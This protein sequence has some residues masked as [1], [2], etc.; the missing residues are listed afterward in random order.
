MSEWQ[1]GLAK[2]I[3]ALF[4]KDWLKKKKE[5]IYTVIC[6]HVLTNS[7]NYKQIYSL[8]LIQSLII[9]ARTPSPFLLC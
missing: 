8:I 4:W 5:Y 3:G 1:K 7:Y 9:G 6:M 2:W